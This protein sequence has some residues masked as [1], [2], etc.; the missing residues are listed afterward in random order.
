MKLLVR[1]RAFFCSI[2]RLFRFLITLFRICYCT[3]GKIQ[4]VRMIVK[5]ELIGMGGLKL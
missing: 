1:N 3:V 4:L 5:G 2:W